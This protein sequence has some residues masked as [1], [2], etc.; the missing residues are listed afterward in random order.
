MSKHFPTLLLHLHKEIVPVVVVCHTPRLCLHC[1][2]SFASGINACSLTI[3]ETS[4]HYAMRRTTMEKQTPSVQHLYSL[5]CTSHLRDIF[6]TPNTAKAPNITRL[7]NSQVSVLL[8]RFRPLLG[9]PGTNPKPLRNHAKS[10]KSTGQATLL[11]NYF[12]VSRPR[13]STARS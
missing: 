9:L 4:T 6:H 10:P 5:R 7:N 13:N 12:V 1:W 2:R 3:S 11:N 8:P